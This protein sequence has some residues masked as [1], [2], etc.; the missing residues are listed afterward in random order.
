MVGWVEL[1]D[2]LASM[3]PRVFPAEDVEQAASYVAKYI[4]LQ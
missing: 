4:A 1:Y 2:A 3:R